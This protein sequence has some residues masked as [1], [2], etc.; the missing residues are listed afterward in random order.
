[1]NSNAEVTM[2]GSTSTIRSAMGTSRSS[3]SVSSAN[4]V[5]EASTSQ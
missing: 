2:R 3:P 1:M 5:T 4:S